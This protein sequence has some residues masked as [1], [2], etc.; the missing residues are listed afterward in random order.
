ML[1]KSIYISC[2]STYRLIYQIFFFII[3]ISLK[4]PISVRLYFFI[5]HVLLIN[6]CFS[7]TFQPKPV[8]AN[9]FF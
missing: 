6:Y 2:V 1:G 5:I 8:R 4:N 9:F 7:L 3:I